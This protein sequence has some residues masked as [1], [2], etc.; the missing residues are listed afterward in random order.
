MAAKTVT[1]KLLRKLYEQHYIE[2]NESE[3]ILQDDSINE[4]LFHFANLT[5]I[6]YSRKDIH[7]KALIEISNIC[8]GTCFYC[9]LRS[10]N[11]EILRYKLKKENIMK[12]AKEAINLG[13]KTIVMQSGQ[14]NAYCV[15]ELC[16]IIKFINELGAR[17]TL[18]LGEKTYEEYLAF[19]KAGANRYLLRIECTD[20][21]IYS[22]LHPKMSLKNRFKCLEYL[23]S[24]HY[25]TGS[26][27]IVGLPQQ[28]C[29]TIANDIDF[30]KKSDFDMI[31]V[32]PFLPCENTPLSQHEHGD[33]LLSLKTMALIRLFMPNINIPAT[34]AMETLVKN[35]RLQ[36]LQCGAN[37]IMPAIADYEHRK[38]YKIYPNKAT[39]DMNL[40]EQRDLII[41]QLSTI[42]SA[43]SN[44]NGDSARFA[45]R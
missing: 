45:L 2:P 28:T 3:E 34:T 10:Q 25:E 37:V 36:A 4:E 6:K 1:Y 32:G 5:R 11:R 8:N 19:K 14:S 40:N 9:G 17:I 44:E 21:Q 30:F 18:S 43:I 35:G 12:V 42:N 23:Q 27:L 26:G 15:D 38:Q 16:E 41:S 13:Y 29:K 39:P 33:F 20:P 31:G 22:K 24:L 7:L